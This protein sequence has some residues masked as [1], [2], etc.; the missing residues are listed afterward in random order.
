MRT[1]RLLVAAACVVA[2]A[3]CTDDILSGPGG[4]GGDFGITV[5]GGTSPTYSWSAGPAFSIDVVRTSN[6]TQVVWRITDPTDPR[7]ISSPVRHGIVPG[8]SVES[9]AVER[10]L[11]P[12]IEYRV[13]IT[14]A[15]QQSAFQDFIP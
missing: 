8:G 3:G 15:N 7:N 2:V 9:S 13:T 1:T 12:G 6:Q 14:L 11:T 4:S 10:V 5:G